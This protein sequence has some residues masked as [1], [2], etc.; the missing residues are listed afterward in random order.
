MKRLILFLFFFLNFSL[1]SFSQEI[2]I[3]TIKDYIINPVIEEYIRENI[4]SAE[5]TSSYLLI[6]LNTPG[7]LLKSTQ[8]I[9]KEILNAKIPVITYI[10]PK[11][12]RAASAGTFIGY[13]SSVL[14]MAPSTH[15]GAAHPVLGGGRWGKLSLEL[16]EK[17]MNDTLAWAKN[18]ARER[19]RPYKFLE[20]AIKES[21]SLTE[22]EALKG[23]IIDLIAENVDELVKKAEGKKIKLADKEIILSL[24]NVKTKFVELNPRQK[25]LN[26]LLE[27]NIA[28][29]LFTLG[30]LG[31]IFEFT[32]PGFG[33]P[34]IAGIICL[35]LALYAFSILPVNYAGLALII[36]GLIFFI[37]EAFTPTFGVFT[38]SG[39][40][41]FILGSILLFR[42]PQ[43]F[44]VSLKIITP[45]SL[46]IAAWGIFILGKVLQAR[47][48]KPQT[49]KEAL[50]GEAGQTL[51]DIDNNI[52]KV[53]IHGEVWQAKSKEKIE[54]GK[55]VEVIGA[56]GLVLEVKR[57]GG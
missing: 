44:K 7:G 4:K 31:L 1:L 54:K 11:G 52:G 17:I 43:I 30:F 19:K 33:F 42:E 51:T 6:R 38:L 23:R 46:V 27:P 45:L 57:K 36:L 37:V 40:I 28:Y 26:A 29:L 35:V 25:F 2:R 9:V 41:S 39:L 8:N 32:H 21:E 14:A 50:I 34:G 22:E 18:I 10:W 24:K 16:Q 53:F 13:A 48:R 20:E 56:E 3:L 12:A 55:E 15:I 47:F 5:E 49:G